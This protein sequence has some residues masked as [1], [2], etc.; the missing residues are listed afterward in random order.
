MININQLPY[1][2]GWND[3]TELRKYPGAI[4]RAKLNNNGSEINLH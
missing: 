1:I 3:G 2:K 4:L